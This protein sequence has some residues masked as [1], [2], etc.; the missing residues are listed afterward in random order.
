[1]GCNR[2]ADSNYQSVKLLSLRI[3][4]CTC[5]IRRIE[6]IP[7]RI[8]TTDRTHTRTGEAATTSDEDNEQEE[9]SRKR[10]ER[11]YPQSFSVRRVMDEDK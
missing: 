1:M 11:A 7:A 10:K 6:A 9:K 3:K 4:V 8:R 2:P 5:S